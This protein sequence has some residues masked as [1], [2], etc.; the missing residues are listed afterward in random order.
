MFLRNISAWPLRNVCN[1]RIVCINEQ[2]NNLVETSEIF[3]NR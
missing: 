1:H 2:K 3:M